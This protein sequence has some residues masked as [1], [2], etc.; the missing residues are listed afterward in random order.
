VEPSST[1][2]ATSSLFPAAVVAIG[3]DSHRDN[4]ES[5]AA[6]TARGNVEIIKDKDG[7]SV[8]PSFYSEWDDSRWTDSTA[9]WNLEIIVLKSYGTLMLR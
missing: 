7:P 9:G 5:L 2:S 1:T 3:Q 6:A 8:F 4:A